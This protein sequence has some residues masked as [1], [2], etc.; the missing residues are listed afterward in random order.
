MTNMIKKSLLTLAAASALSLAVIPC[1]SARQV[2]GGAGAHQTDADAPC[3]THQ[4]GVVFST[5]G[6]L[7]AYEVQ[8]ATDTTGSKVVSFTGNG[9][10]SCN[11]NV[12][13]PAGTAFFNTTAQTAA[14][15]SFTTKTFGALPVGSP[16][17]MW[18]RCDFPVS[19]ILSQVSWTT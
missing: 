6:G 2:G 4:N 7:R 9:G 13:N 15:A 3:F 1:V 12:N 5:C 18:L 8:L 16:G 10:V 17:I 11:S 19:A 14:G